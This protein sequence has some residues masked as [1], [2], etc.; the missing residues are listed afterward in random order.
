MTD[1]EIVG[2]IGGV[3][4]SDS[5]SDDGLERKRSVTPSQ[6]CEAFG[7]A[8]EWDTDLLHLLLVKKWN[9]IAAS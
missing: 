4:D 1:A 8:L 3:C 9:G 2:E 7:T 5:E 6:A